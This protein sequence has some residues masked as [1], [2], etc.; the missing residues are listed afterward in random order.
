MNRL[1]V[2]LSLAFGLVMLIATSF[3]ILTPAIVVRFSE[4]R[5][6]PSPEALLAPGGTVDQ[7]AAYYQTHQS[8]DGVES[9]LTTPTDGPAP[10]VVR[11]V[12]PGTDGQ[13]IRYGTRIGNHMTWWETV[14]VEVDGEVVAYL[15]IAPTWAKK[16]PPEPGPAA[17][18]DRSSFFLREMSRFLWYFGIAGGV[19]G[20]LFG[21]IMSRSMAA[22]LGNLAKAARAIAGRD[23]SYRVTPSGSQEMIEV[24]EAFNDMAAELEKGEELRRHLMADVAHELRTPLTVIQGN[25]RAVLDDI[26]PLD[27]REIANLYD[28]TR[29]LSRLVDDLH[30][31][32]LA[33]A[34]KLDM[35]FELVDPAALAQ[36]AADIFAPVVESRQV[37]LVTDTASDVPAISGDSTRLKQVLHNLLTNAMRHTPAGGTITLKAGKYESGVYLSVIDTGEGISADHLPHVFDRFYRADRSRSRGGGAGAGLGLAIVRA[38]VQAHGGT[39]EV[40]SE[41]IKG[42]GTTFTVILPIPETEITE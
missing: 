8:W 24:G 13:F 20:I 5:L 10:F 1:W 21:V 30:E 35:R 25:L 23:L 12:A 3:V 17:P 9:I 32:T 7:V 37:R 42:L 15:E 16:R 28:Q 34:G 14:P 19:F 31:L 29:L 41:G 22:P 39:V 6:P 26:Y 36:N 27:K 33:E 40:T 11:L 2:R 18:L 4:P 38:I